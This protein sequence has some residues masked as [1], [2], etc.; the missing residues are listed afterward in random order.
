MTQIEK[1]IAE[2][3]SSKTEIHTGSTTIS[4]VA[5]DLPASAREQIVRILAERRAAIRGV[6][7]GGSHVEQVIVIGTQGQK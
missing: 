5:F 4:T 6:V 3:A 7:G 2:I 1:Q